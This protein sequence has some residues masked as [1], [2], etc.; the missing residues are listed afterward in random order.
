MYIKALLALSAI[1]GVLYGY[2]VNL[3]AIFAHMDA[4]F[5]AMLFVRVVGVFVAP[6]GVVA[7]YF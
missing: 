3:F 1:A 5:T 2:I 7:G 6:L 4:G